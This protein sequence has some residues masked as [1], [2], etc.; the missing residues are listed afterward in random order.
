MSGLQIFAAILLVMNLVLLGLNLVIGSYPLALVN[1]LA[2][3]TNIWVL[4]D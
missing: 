4:V 2:A 3:A 1:V